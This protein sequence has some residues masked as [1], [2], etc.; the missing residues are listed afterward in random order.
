M[1]VN[2]PWPP[3]EVLDGP[4]ILSE[5]VK[6]ILHHPNLHSA[7]MQCRMVHLSGKSGSDRPW[8][9]CLLLAKNAIHMGDAQ[10][11]TDTSLTEQSLCS[12]AGRPLWS[13]LLLAA[14][15]WTAI[16]KPSTVMPIKAGVW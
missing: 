8:L 16:L 7:D 6:E 13:G 9:P 15:S 14:A 5:T 12:D 10:A 1:G 2:L 4:A 3:H 11:A